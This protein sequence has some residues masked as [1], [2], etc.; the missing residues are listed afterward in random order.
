MIMKKINR[1]R[2]RQ[3]E[4]KEIDSRNTEINNVLLYLIYALPDAD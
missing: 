4:G 1:I 2:N 3:A